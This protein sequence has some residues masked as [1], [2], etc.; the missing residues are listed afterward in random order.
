MVE[1]VVGSLGLSG[2]DEPDRSSSSFK[3]PR[4]T[5]KGRPPK[6]LSTKECECSRECGS[7][8]NSCSLKYVFRG[9]A[10]DFKRFSFCGKFGIFF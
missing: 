7:S 2:G 1:A 5:Q 4:S 10:T 9:A 3:E 8:G 6:A